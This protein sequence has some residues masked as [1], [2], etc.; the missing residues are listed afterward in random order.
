MS[1]SFDVYL[2]INYG[3]MRPYSRE[4]WIYLF[5]LPFVER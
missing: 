2:E 4:V 1:I 5:A 3:L